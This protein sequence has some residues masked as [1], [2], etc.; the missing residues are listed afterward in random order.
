MEMNENHREV[1]SA[2]LGVKKLSPETEALYF[3]VKKM[4]DRRDVFFNPQ[5][6]LMIACL[7]K[8][9]MD[10]EQVLSAD[11]PEETVANTS[12]TQDGSV[13]KENPP[14]PQLEDKPC[15]VFYNGQEEKALL[16]G[17]QQGTDETMYRVKLLAGKG[18]NTII[19]VVKH[20]VK[21]KE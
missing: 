7:S 5:V 20:N 1:L 21:L 17:D 16:L 13:T 9:Q 4:A 14:K 10:I 15:S 3:A 2:L 18:K 19:E 12:L 6:L 8:V 11:L